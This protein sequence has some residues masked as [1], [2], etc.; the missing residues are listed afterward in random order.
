[1]QNAVCLGDVDNDGDHELVIGNF[2]GDLA[3]FKG[4]DP[5]PWK[6]CTG[7]GQISAVR[8]G[9]L[10]NEGRNVLV[11]LT[12]DGWCYVFDF[13]KEYEDE[14]DK[15]TTPESSS[16]PKKD[17]TPEEAESLME[18][19]V[20]SEPAL[21]TNSS[22][23][24]NETP[25]SNQEVSVGQSDHNIKKMD[26]ANT[27]ADPALNSSESSPP[28]ALSRSNGGT[29]VQGNSSNPHDKSPVEKEELPKSPTAN[30]S[31]SGI[32]GNSQSPGSPLNRSSDNS[33]NDSSKSSTEP[34][35]SRPDGWQK[36]TSP[37]SDLDKSEAN[38][39]S[40][41]ESSKSPKVPLTQSSPQKSMSPKSDLSTSRGPE[42][43]SPS[44]LNESGKDSSK[45]PVALSNK[46]P[47]D[48]SNKSLSSKSD[49]L[50][51]S[52]RETPPSLQVEPPSRSGSI[53]P[54]SL[55]IG[56]PSPQKQDISSPSGS[57]S[58]S[59][60]SD[61]LNVSRGGEI[62]DRE[63]ISPSDVVTSPVP[64][65]SSSPVEPKEMTQNKSPEVKEDK[66]MDYENEINESAE[67]VDQTM[68]DEVNEED[69]GEEEMTEE[70]PDEDIKTKKNV[71][72]AIGSFEETVPVMPP[73][74]Q[75]CVQKSYLKYS[76]G[77]K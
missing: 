32:I 43:F 41:G 48:A 2:D 24:A 51:Q 69:E 36:S 35:V 72:F 57:G 71:E 1:M 70:S 19:L 38:T 44:S 26:S 3:V 28:S 37:R 67:K 59:K 11:V 56:T 39:T 47:G 4:N 34:S 61:S 18:N 75:V 16:P 20:I 46:S 22:P 42:N 33:N 27:S 17:G 68:E 73:Q 31:P 29:P 14:V 7:L 40:G 64:L 8:I 9:D 30:I 45:S 49:D 65:K 63:E 54:R 15:S 13:N 25:P 52:A 77:G 58:S 23:S 6:K 12:A 62:G 55:N 10:N 74:F 66:Q 21:P 76:G 53:S 50:D 60:S 5:Q